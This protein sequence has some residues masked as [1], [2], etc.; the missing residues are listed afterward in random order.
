MSG[1]RLRSQSRSEPCQQRERSKEARVTR[2]FAYR[3]AQ[4]GIPGRLPVEMP[5]MEQAWPGSGCAATLNACLEKSVATVGFE[6]RVAGGVLLPSRRFCPEQHGSMPGA[7]FRKEHKIWCQP[8][9][10]LPS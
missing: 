5:C 7:L 2:A 9:L 6:G 3:V 8:D 4:Q 10:P 1:K